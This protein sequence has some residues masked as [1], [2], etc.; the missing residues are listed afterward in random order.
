[1]QS[2]EAAE[3]TQTFKRAPG[4]WWYLGVPNWIN[5][6]ASV[7]HPTTRRRRSK[8]VLCKLWLKARS[9]KR[10]PPKN[11]PHWWGCP[12]GIYCRFAHGPEELDNINKSPAPSEQDRR[13][14][15]SIARI[16]DTYENMKDIQQNMSNAVQLGLRRSNASPIAD[17]SGVEIDADA[18]DANGSICLGGQVGFGATGE[19]QGRS[20][21][22]TVGAMSHGS[23]KG[24]LYYEVE[25]L[26]GYLSQVGWASTTFS[27]NE[28]DASGVGDEPE[29][30][31]YDGARA[32]SKGDSV[33]A[34][35]GKRNVGDVVGCIFDVKCHTR[36]LFKW[37]RR[38]LYACNLNVK[39]LY[40]CISLESGEIVRKVY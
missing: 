28:V 1:M 26:T 15:E 10:C 3:K 11:A 18:G 12:N 5:I 22:A 38:E 2:P 40:L 7:K 37:R 23:D 25:I 14:A 30:W 29:S 17:D 24:L 27:P 39:T 16:Q 21:F 4:L 6:G 35:Y 19:I 31:A 9:G 36:I 8:T 20:Q 34:P 13:E 32:K 33:I